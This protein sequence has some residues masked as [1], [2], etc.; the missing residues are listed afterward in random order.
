MKT[1]DPSL[2]CSLLFWTEII[3]F[4]VNFYIIRPQAPVPHRNAVIDYRLL[5]SKDT[6]ADDYQ[7]IFR[8]GIGSMRPIRSFSVQQVS[9]TSII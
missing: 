7:E 9:L 2:G 8:R 6:L 1:L 5:Q 4:F 3:N